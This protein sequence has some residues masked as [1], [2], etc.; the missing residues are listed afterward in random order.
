LYNICTTFVQRLYNI[1]LCN[2][3]TTFVCLFGYFH[4]KTTETYYRF[5]SDI[6]SAS[7]G[8]WRPKWAMMDFEDGLKKAC[9]QHDII[10]R[11]CWFHYKKAI[12]LWL[13][14]NR[15]YSEHLVPH[16]IKQ[17]TDGI[18]LARTIEAAHTLVNELKTQLHGN[19]TVVLLLH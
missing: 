11:G 5:I 17:I 18:F 9:R 4:S 15:H 1:C 8:R 16:D 14:D 19:L 10:V 3:C 2:I 13:Y 12:D 6:K 7:A